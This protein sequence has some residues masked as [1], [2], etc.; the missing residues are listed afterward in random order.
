MGGW[1]D[2]ETTRML[3]AELKLQVQGVREEQL[4]N[5]MNHIEKLIVVAIQ[6]S[7]D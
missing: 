6:T 4:K 5:V 7:Q 2:E 1:I 3:L